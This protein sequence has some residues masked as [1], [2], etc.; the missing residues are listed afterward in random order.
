MTA[1]RPSAPLLDCG[2]PFHTFDVLHSAALLG[3]VAGPRPVGLGLL[4]LEL[5]YQRVRPHDIDIWDVGRPRLRVKKSLWCVS[6]WGLW[7]TEN[8]AFRYG[9]IAKLEYIW[10]IL[11]RT[12]ALAEETIFTGHA[13]VE[14]P[15]GRVAAVALDPTR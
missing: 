9:Q 5:F 4:I 14:P 2:W 1:S 7:L 15:P 8:L 13:V 12:G 3:V 11:P 10:L 6:V